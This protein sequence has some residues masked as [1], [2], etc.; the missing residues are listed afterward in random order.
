MQVDVEQRNRCWGERLTTCLFTAR[1]I[2]TMFSAEKTC[3]SSFIYNPLVLERIID[4][5]HSSGLDDE[6]QSN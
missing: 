5:P 3:A 4:T 1:V 6:Q 2:L